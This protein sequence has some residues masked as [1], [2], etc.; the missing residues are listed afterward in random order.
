MRCT[1]V[2]RALEVAP[3]AKETTSAVHPLDISIQRLAVEAREAS[4][5]DVR[6][7]FLWQGI[8]LRA[9]SAVPL[10][11]LRHVA[12]LLGSSVKVGLVDE[13]FLTAMTGRLESLL[14]WGHVE[15]SKAK[16]NADVIVCCNA[17]LRAGLEVQS[18]IYEEMLR[19]V[20]RNLS[21]LR[22]FE[23]ALLASCLARMRRRDPVLLRGARQVVEAAA[24]EGAK[25]TL[26]RGSMLLQALSILEPEQRP[27]ALCTAVEGTLQSWWASEDFQLPPEVLQRSLLSLVQAEVAWINKEQ[28]APP[29]LMRSVAEYLA[30]PTGHGLWPVSALPAVATA[31]QRWGEDIPSMSKVAARLLR[32]LQRRLARSSHRGLSPALLLECFGAALPLAQHSR[33]PIQRI[34][35]H[36]LPRATDLRPGQLVALVE[37][38][39]LAWEGATEEDQKALQ[40]SLSELRSVVY[41][42]LRDI[43]LRAIPRALAA[44]LQMVSKD[45]I[46]SDF[47]PILRRSTGRLAYKLR[48]VV[49]GTSTADDFDTDALGEVFYVCAA[50]SYSDDA[51]LEASEAW[52][53]KSEADL[54]KPLTLV[55]LLHSA[56]VLHVARGQLLHVLVAASVEHM[57]RFGA[58]EVLG[59]LDAAALL[60]READQ[61]TPADFMEKDG[62]PPS[63]VGEQALRA[64]LERLQVLM[65]S[66]DDENLLHF[67]HLLRATRLP[68]DRKSVV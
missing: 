40:N 29:A 48:E 51:F 46:Q 26:L 54:K 50:T 2:L 39:A 55:H 63:G 28:L 22:P 61:P 16:S 66:L 1:R 34:L 33:E 32:V 21:S 15:S 49:E 4:A 52:L 17:L 19:A 8:R 41:R 27:E 60:Q 31:L 13:A 20:A 42:R 12:D 5:K 38:C 14:R 37:L 35:Q 47:W 56:A 57:D 11:H 23:A 64:S 7:P 53:L 45:A 10:L 62:P 24:T 36:L 65:P 44:F 58:F 18:P 43:P 25:E 3:W 30:G 6:D 68:V 9:R 67:V 59:F